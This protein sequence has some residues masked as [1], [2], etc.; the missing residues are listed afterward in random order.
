MGTS[1]QLVI[2]DMIHFK[3][4]KIGDPGADEVCW[5]NTRLMDEVFGKLHKKCAVP[6]CNYPISSLR[7]ENFI[8][9]DVGEVCTVCHDMYAS[10]IFINKQLVDRDYYLK[11]HVQW[12]K[13]N[14]EQIRKRKRWGDL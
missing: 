6:D 9:T 1:Y 11:H 5:K 10:L 13:E 3:T 14:E 7:V 12:R 8:V 4:W 2:Y